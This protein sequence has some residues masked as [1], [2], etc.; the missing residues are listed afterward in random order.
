MTQDDKPSLKE[1]VFKLMKND[2]EK[3]TSQN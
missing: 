2:L 1:K 3:V